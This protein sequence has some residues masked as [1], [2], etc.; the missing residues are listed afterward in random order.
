MPQQYYAT[1]TC[2]ACGTKFQT[3]IEQILDVR[4][5]PEAKRRLLNGNVNLTACPACGAVARLNLPFVYHDPEKEVVLLYL[6]IE[7]G[8]SEVERQKYAGNLTRQLMDS[9]PSEERKGYLFQTET[10]I[11][12]ETLIRRVLELEGVT[13]ED[14]EHTQKQQEFF[15]NLVQASP[16]MWDTMIGEHE[17]LIDESLFT[18]LNYT[19]QVAAMSGQEESED[20]QRLEELVDY[21]VENHPLGQALGKRT[22]VVQPFLENPSRET[23][24]EALSQAPDEE[25]VNMLIQTGLPLM[26]YAFFQA[27]V[28]EIDSAETEEEK[29][30]L[31]KIRRKILDVRDQVAEAQ[32]NQARER[33][34]L[35]RR[36]LSTEEPLKMA[37]SHRSELDELFFL[38]LRSELEEAREDQNE[39][40]REALEQV[41]QTVERVVEEDMPP[42]LILVRRL[43]FARNDEELE[44]T[45]KNN[46]EMLQ[47]R[48]F[49]VLESLEQSS[50]ERGDEESA[51][52]LARIKA[53]AQLIA[54]PEATQP[55]PNL[56]TPGAMSPGGPRPTP[57]SDTETGTKTDSGLIIAKR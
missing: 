38:V 56:L 17:D 54:P 32:E 11:N 19:M 57:D 18:M 22:E 20:F 31:T 16:E 48:F 55:Q 13:E 36:L 41:G 6:P 9:L 28:R 1:V 43:L 53:K 15:R 26:D 23:L 44:Q 3:P 42:E 51:E 37:R 8:R 46:R 33:A 50:R 7:S 25:S 2:S 30:H 14:M 12:M 35:L 49:N 4:I 40:Y 24:I 5:D 27:L 29:K 39:S 10:F 47:T 52:H 45:L 21:L 34:T